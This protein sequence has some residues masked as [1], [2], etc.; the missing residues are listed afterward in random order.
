[1][2]CSGSDLVAAIWP[3]QRVLSLS[4]YGPFTRRWRSA[5]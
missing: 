5:T 3:L 4:I 1:V 2:K